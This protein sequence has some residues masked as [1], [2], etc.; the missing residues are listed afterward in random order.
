V[1]ACAAATAVHAAQAEP[2]TYTTE[3]TESLLRIDG[4]LDEADWGLVDWSGDFVQRELAEGEPPSAQTAFKI[5]YDHANLYVAFRAYDA[6]PEKI[7]RILGRRD[8]F[9][10]DWVEINIDSRHDHRTAFSFTASVSGTQGDE[11]ISQ[12]GDSWDGNWDP[13][14]EHQARVDGDGW[15]AEARIPLSQL[16][17]ADREEHV[18]GIQVQR[19]IYRREERSVWQPIPK[20]QDGWV[21]KFG[22][23]RGVRGIGPGRR[24]EILPYTLA[25]GER[26]EKV[27]GNPFADG[28]EGKFSGGLDGKFGVTSDLTLDVSVNPDFGQVEADPSVVNLTAFETFFEEKRPLFIEGANIF[29]F[30]IAPSI[31]F[32]THTQDQIFYSRRIGRRPQSTPDLQ[33]GES[34]DQPENTSI[35][36]AAK[37]TGKTG[38]GLS[39]AVLESVAARE[40]AEI[41]LDGSRRKATVEPLTNYFVGR[42][43]QDFRKG[44]TRLGGMVT[45][46]NRGIDDP[47]VDFLHTSAYVGGMDFF[48]YV[49]ERRYYSAVNLLGSRVAG[50]EEAI[51]R[52]Q[53]APARYYQRPDNDGQ[54]VDTT[55]T[56]L[57]GHAGSVRVGKS[58]GRLLFE[59]GAA[60]RSPG[61][62]MNDAGFLRNADEINQFS[63]IGYYFRNPF[64]IFRRMQL[65]F[66]QWL[67]FEYGGENLYQAANFNTNANFRNNWNYNASVTRENERISASE[68]RGGPSIKLPGNLNTNVGLNSDWRR[69]LSGGIGGS[70]TRWDDGAGRYRNAWT[71]LVWRPT[72]AIRAEI[73]PSYSRNEP[74]FQFVDTVDDGGDPAYVY[75]SLD[76]RTFDLSFRLD[77]SVTPTLTIQYYG[78]PFVSAGRYRDFKR[79]TNPRGD[80]YG[81][82]FRRLDGAVRFD[83]ADDAYFVDEDGDGTDDYEFGDPDFNVRDFNS[84]LVVRWQ[85]SP[86]SRVFLVWSQS[87]S[88]FESAGRFD[89]R[90]DMRAL[91]DVHPHN[92]F[93]VKLDHWINL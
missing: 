60:W 75:A 48:H 11:F 17:Y 40:R 52:T 81:D 39:I 30:R 3:R 73:E 67:D 12:D 87:R 35:L 37:L 58:Q 47:E 31:A 64:G 45:A 25:R 79:V 4:R 70:A 18:W 8:D 42:L 78:A 51:E 13:V 86:G 7:A 33:D 44:K 82:R 21:S 65:N 61:F 92:V 90:D 14:W 59:T 66:N 34:L 91:F 55:R 15:T 80:R 46:V 36:G 89:L 93:L 19:R 27:S 62:E 88:G 22:E 76:Q 54:S 49:G 56:E 63:W 84:N 26:F 10:G 23:L 28:A 43:Q 50:S 20:D 5:L 9:P 1:A 77:Y 41:D 38:G 53:R 29:D 57:A 74:E 2:R 72:N 69:Q 6:E 83:E 71:Y 32:G 68:L 24:V 16:R 85:Y